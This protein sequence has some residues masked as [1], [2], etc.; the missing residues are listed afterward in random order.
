MIPDEYVTQLREMVA[1]FDVAAREYNI[2]KDQ[3]LDKAEDYE[4]AANALAVSIEMLLALN[5]DD[6]PQDAAATERQE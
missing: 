5:H 6:P 2:A 1:A 4:I 3:L